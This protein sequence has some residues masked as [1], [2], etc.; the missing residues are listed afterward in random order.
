MQ[1]LFWKTKDFFLSY[2]LNELKNISRSVDLKFFI[3]TS[4]LQSCC[5]ENF[6]VRQEEKG[7]SGTPGTFLLGPPPRDL[8]LGPPPGS[9][10]DTVISGTCCTNLLKFLDP[11]VAL[12]VTFKMLYLLTS[13]H[14]LQVF[15]F[16][17]YDPSLSFS[18]EHW[19]DILPSKQLDPLKKK[20]IILQ[21]LISRKVI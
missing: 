2:N 8:P 6:G 9:I 21:V 5:S 14:S 18:T 15:S 19:Y 4:N 12:C 13:D 11:S 7:G 10:T 3:L 16:A 17:R 1:A 20:Q